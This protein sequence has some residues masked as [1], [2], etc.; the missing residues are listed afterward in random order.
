MNL[1][2]N[3]TMG[4]FKCEIEHCTFIYSE[5]TSRI[6]FLCGTLN[7]VGICKKHYEQTKYYKYFCFSCSNS[8][9]I[10]FLPQ[11]NNKYL[12]WINYK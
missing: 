9:K 5:G 6:C 8:E 1:D 2:F 12:I 3:V 10:K 7:M 4:K 11:F